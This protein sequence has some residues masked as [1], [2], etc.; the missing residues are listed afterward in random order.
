MYIQV[1]DRKGN[2]REREEKRERERKREREGGG[3][4]KERER[5]E[6]R[7]RERERERGLKERGR[8]SSVLM[9][10]TYMYMCA[11]LHYTTPSLPPTLCE[12]PCTFK[13][14]VVSFPPACT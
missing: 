1:I 12:M 3:G 4:L 14:I 6:K 8:E 13:T 7:E 9:K 11:S 5:E 10:F 2:E